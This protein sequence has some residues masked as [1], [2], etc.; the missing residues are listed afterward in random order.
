VSKHKISRLRRFRCNLIRAANNS[1]E[2]GLL[3]GCSEA[4]NNPAVVL[5]RGRNGE[6]SNPVVCEVPVDGADHPPVPCLVGLDPPPAEW[7]PIE[8]P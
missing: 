4:D 6:G 3:R 5:L 8:Y 7:M 1:P 2:E